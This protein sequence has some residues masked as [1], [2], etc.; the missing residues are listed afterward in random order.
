MNIDEFIRPSSAEPIE[1]CP[2]RPRM[3]ARAVRLVPTLR[4]LCS[5]AA[6]QGTMGHEVMAG[7]ARDAFAG[8][9][10]QAQA[11]ISGIEGRMAGLAYWCKDAVR[12][13]IAYLCDLVRRHIPRYPN[14]QILAE[15]RL[16]G[17]G[18]LI[19][20]GGTA[21]LV[22]LCRDAD[23]VLDL[24]VVVDWKTGFVSQG[25]AADHLQLACYAV[26]AADR[27]KPRHGVVVH[28]AMGRRK[29]FSSA[30]YDS[31]AVAGVRA[32]IQ[33]AVLAARAEAPPLRPSLK[34]CRYCK[35][36]LL[37]RA[38]RE[39]LMDAFD[40][41]ALFGAEPADRLQLADA[42]ALAKRFA[43]DGDAVLKQMRAQEADAA[44]RRSTPAAN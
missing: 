31:E 12:T 17:D 6:R 9:W 38:A 36:L 29:E 32:R 1:L 34:A 4:D 16:P 43:A 7:V 35:A 15:E 44:S 27:W 28:L 14:V 18:I 40:Q 20:R 5:E 24:V 25:E 33:R 26:M 30:M 19:P 11:V 42:I 21:D 8:D 10:S 13:C 23:G 39:Y 37:C 22:L 2:G 3:E 41:L